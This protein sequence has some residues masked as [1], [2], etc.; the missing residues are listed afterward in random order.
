LERSL[1]EAEGGHTDGISEQPQEY[2]RRVVAFFDE[3]LGS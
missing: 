1:W 3:A 2:E